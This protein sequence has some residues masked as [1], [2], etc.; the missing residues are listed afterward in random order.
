MP[1]VLVSVLLACLFVLPFGW[2]PVSGE[3][4]PA[5]CEQVFAATSRGGG[6]APVGGGGCSILGREGSS[7]V[8][9]IRVIDGDTIRVSGGRRIR[10]VGVDTPE[11]GDG[12]SILG[13][14]QRSSIRVWYRDER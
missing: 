1:R 4:A 2:R 6:G 9:V 5:G 10:Y 13:P 11:V 8:E 14:R 12:P 3:E 7:R